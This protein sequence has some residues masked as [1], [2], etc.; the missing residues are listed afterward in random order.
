MEETNLKI[1]IDALEISNELLEAAETHD[2]EV[3]DELIEKRNSMLKAVYADLDGTRVIN[4]EKSRTLHALLGINK[5][6]IQLANERK[7][8]IADKI[9]QIR[10][11]DKIN[12]SYYG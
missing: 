6:T 7:Q 2:M 1:Y 11:A 4:L 3:V 12:K 9:K 5:R 8:E 10:N